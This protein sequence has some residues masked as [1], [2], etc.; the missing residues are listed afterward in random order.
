[1]E[2][3]MFTFSKQDIDAVVEIRRRLKKE[4]N[5]SIMLSSPTLM[6]DLADCCYMS[7]DAIT[8][9]RI[10][11][12]LNEKQHNWSDPMVEDLKLHNHAV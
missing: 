12:F 5:V 11:S 1:M 9:S 4:I 10:R 8:R 2:S 3:D 6:D 7:R